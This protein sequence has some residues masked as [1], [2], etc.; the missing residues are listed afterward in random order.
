MLQAKID[1]GGYFLRCA[2]DPDTGST[3]GLAPLA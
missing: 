3:E 2:N 1:A